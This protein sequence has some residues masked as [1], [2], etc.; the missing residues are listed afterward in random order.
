MNQTPSEDIPPDPNDRSQNRSASTGAPDTID[1]VV[2]LWL[3][4]LA[5]IA[6]AIATRENIRNGGPDAE[7]S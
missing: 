2:D 1:P 5:S 4:S 3:Q 7:S 6:V